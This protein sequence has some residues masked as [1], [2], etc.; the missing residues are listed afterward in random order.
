M[1]LN[2]SHF[3]TY[4][5]KSFFM[6]KYISVDVV[7]FDIYY[8]GSTHNWRQIRTNTYAHEI[9]FIFIF[10]FFYFMFY[11][12]SSRTV[13]WRSFNRIITHEILQFLLFS[14]NLSVQNFFLFT[15]C[16]FINENFL[17]K[18]KFCCILLNYFNEVFSLYR[19]NFIFLY[20]VNKFLIYMY[21]FIIRFKIF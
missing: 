12:K 16:Y 3:C 13:F 4:F 11:A 8:I 19:P 10:D 21:I 5:V 14:I 2:F 9:S 20:K 1:S 15:F 7:S 6:P 17:W 18:Q